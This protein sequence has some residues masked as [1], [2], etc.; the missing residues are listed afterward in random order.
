M[1]LTRLLRQL[2][3]NPDTLL[4][5]DCIG[6]IDKNYLFTPTSFTN[7]NQHNEAGQNN[8]S[9]KIFAFAQ[10]QNLTQQQTL[11]CF[12]EYYRLDVLEHPQAEDH[13]NIRQFIVNGWQGIKFEGYPLAPG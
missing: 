12:G 13:Q 6:H 10:L 1:D 9:C 2:Q 3:Q 8:G 4:F 5:S 11:S 7:G